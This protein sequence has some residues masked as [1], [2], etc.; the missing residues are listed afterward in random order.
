M[1]ASQN[2]SI[3][4]VEDSVDLLQIYKRILSRKGYKVYAAADGNTGLDI[5][6]KTE[7]S[8]L[9]LDIV[10]PDISGF[11]ILHK[12]KSGEISPDTLVVML[13]SFRKSSDDQAKGLEMGADGFIA[14][15]VKERELLARVEA[16]MRLKLTIN[17]LKSSQKRLKLITD[18]ISDGIVIVDKKGVIR[19]CNP[20]AAGLFST[21]IEGLINKPIGHPVLSKEDCVIDIPNK[22]RESI[23]YAELRTVKINW[24]NEE[25]DLVSLRDITDRKRD[26]IKLRMAMRRAEES[27]SLKSAFLA[28]M[29]HEI[30]TPLN[31]IVGFSSLL[32]S[33]SLNPEKTR[34]YLQLIQKSGDQ[35]LRIVNDILDIAKIESGQLDINKE[36]FLVE[37]LLTESIDRYEVL[38]QKSHK[39]KLII[40]F[41]LHKNISGLVVSADKN[42]LVQVIDNIV[43]NAIKFT[44]EGSISVNCRKVFWNELEHIEIEVADTGKGMSKEQLK[45][46]FERFRQ[47]D[48]SSFTSGTGLGLSISKGLILLMGGDIGIESEPDK[49]TIVR[50]VLPIGDNSITETESIEEELFTKAFD[51]SDKLIYIA[52]DDYHS[53]LY[54]SELLSETKAEIKHAENGRVLVNL[55]KRKVPDCILL[56]IN[57][58][59]MS[60]IQAIPYIRNIS[61][62]VLIV[63]QT[64]YA[65]NEEK[66]SI[67]ASGCDFYLAKPVSQKELFSILNHHLT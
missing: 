4:I 33:R 50:I 43:Q 46:V 22:T 40:N 25:M 19:F 38:R 15:P 6:A 59:V 17:E 8:L 7:I 30:R 26:E 67:L 28:N 45:Y 44:H 13:S 66:Q 42:R 62:D 1:S 48:P 34:K 9:L 61:K 29:S 27:E 3:L 20:S 56:D 55:V 21:T 36:D 35:L 49:G 18:K 51:F 23:V 16:Y 14:K 2:N 52:E 65:L 60:G 24:N 53:F 64:A 58:P 31:S 10:L 39:D 5:L 57:M 12:I 32:T 11:D 41:N 37:E 54:L 63:A 47:A